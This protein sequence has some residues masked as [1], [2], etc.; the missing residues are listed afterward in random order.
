M[1]GYFNHAAGT[2]FTCVDSH[3]YTLRGGSKSTDGKL[4]YM[5][6][7]TCNSLQ[8]PPYVE[9]REIVCAVCSKE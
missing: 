7:A 5:V 6:E 3:P 1:A 4:F 9:G 2:T 8:C